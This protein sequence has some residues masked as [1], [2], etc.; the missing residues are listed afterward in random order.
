M[1][2]GPFRKSNTISLEVLIAGYVLFNI[3]CFAT[4]IGFIFLKGAFQALGIALV[5]GS[6][7]S[8]GTSMAQWWD[9][10]WQK[11]KDVLDRAYGDIRYVKLRRLVKE[12]KKLDKECDKLD[13]KLNSLAELSGQDNI[14]EISR[15]RSED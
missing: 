4:G 8:F 1:K 11:Q 2:L 12:C 15:E 5:V 13:E 7:F 10:A 9:H 14:S 6:V 3:I